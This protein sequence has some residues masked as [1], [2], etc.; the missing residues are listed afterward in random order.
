[1]PA[2]TGPV[3]SDLS[4]LRPETTAVMNPPVAFKKLPFDPHEVLKE[5]ENLQFKPGGEPDFGN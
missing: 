2:A 1:M 3:Y 5:L 4:N